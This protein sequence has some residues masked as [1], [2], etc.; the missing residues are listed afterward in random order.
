MAL[1]RTL[2]ALAGATAKLTEQLSK[3]REYRQA[4]ITVAVTGQVAI[5]EEAA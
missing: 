4:L 2:A 1:E 5:P 3:L